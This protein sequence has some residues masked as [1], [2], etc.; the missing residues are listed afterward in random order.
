MTGTQ[1]DSSHSF[2][3]QKHGLSGRCPECDSPHIFVG[4]HEDGTT[5]LV[6][7]ECGDLGAFGREVCPRC[8][9]RDMMKLPDRRKEEYRCK[10]CGQDNYPGNYELMYHE[11]TGKETCF[12]CYKYV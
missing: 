8:Y 11:D 3:R 7:E 2:D 10:D 12:S 6:C 1:A 5:H 4:H 9:G